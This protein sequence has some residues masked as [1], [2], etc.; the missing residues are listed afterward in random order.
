EHARE[1]TIEIEA[2]VA[3]QGARCASLVDA[4][5]TKVDVPPAGEAVLVV[6]LRLPVPQQHERR[7]QAVTF[8]RLAEPR[9]AL[10]F[11]SSERIAWSASRQALARNFERCG[12][13]P[14]TGSGRSK[15]SLNGISRVIDTQ[16]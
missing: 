6:P 8:S 1:A 13:Q 7:H 10:A 9:S 3:Q 12:D 4:L 14:K 16:P 11:F 2:L 5:V 15:L